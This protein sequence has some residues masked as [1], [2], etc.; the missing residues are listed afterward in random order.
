MSYILPLRVAC[1]LGVASA[2]TL[3]QAEELDC[4]VMSDSAY[5]EFRNACKP[6]FM[7]LG[8]QK[9]GTS[10]L[11]ELMIQ[12][13]SIVGSDIK[14]PNWFSYGNGDVPSNSR[15]GTSTEDFHAYLSQ[16]FKGAQTK[17]QDKSVVA[18]EWSATY[19]HCPCCPEVLHAFVPHVRL[20]A[21]L[22]DPIQRALSR[23]Y[24]QHDAIHDIADTDASF[25]HY[26]EKHLPLLQ[27]CLSTATTVLAET[28]CLAE[29]NI[30]GPSIYEIPIQNYLA[31]FSQDQ[32]LVTYLDRLEDQPA[33]FMEKIERHLR[34]RN[35]QYQ[36]IT[37]K[38]NAEGEYG[39][40]KA[41]L[42]EA[43]KTEVH[44]IS[45][46]TH[47][48]LYEFYRPHVRQLKNIADHGMTEP[49]PSKWIR[50]WGLAGKQSHTESHTVS[51]GGN[52]R[53]LR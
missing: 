40:D 39:W 44:P 36:H 33:M 51:Y 53:A 10:T 21:I 13:P 27:E 17:M 38:Y 23:F 42:L 24:E 49:M 47:T 8:P 52:V 15:C 1:F 32:L 6:K 48:R 22:R 11:W 45:Q 4:D 19:L 46:E 26:V 16:T 2:I 30:L 12:H 3:Q 50:D 35:F 20:V 43:Q 29:E 41:S 7:V 5:G 31:H 18:G 9:C 37:S 34:V 14:E 28:T 25:D